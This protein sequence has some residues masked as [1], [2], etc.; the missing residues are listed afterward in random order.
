MMRKTLLFC[1]SV[2]VASGWMNAQEWSREDS[3]W[4]RNVI[5][6]NEEIQ[7]NEETKKAIEEGRLIM[8]SWMRDAENRVNKVDILKDFNDSGKMDSVRFQ[9][10]D[11]Y[12][13]P[14]A[15]FA[16]YVLYMN[17]IDSI[18]A[19]MTCML[20]A[21]EQKN[22]ESFL[23]P[24]A[25][26]GVFV[27]GTTGGIGGLNFNHLLSMAFSP[28]YRR[29]AHN[30]KH[31]TAY[32]NYYDAGVA[33]ARGFTERERRMIRQD[34]MNFKVSKDVSVGVKTHGIDE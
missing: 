33:P 12:S 29:L 20:T 13:M 34:L 8:P 14:P 3:L 17:K 6:S 23:P 7:I 2:T 15:V 5:E 32:K 10:I 9:S 16:L 21:E 28:S 11:P 31:A 4:L 27:S 30:S 1:F 26:R 25:R 22:I 18:N 24:E 19:S